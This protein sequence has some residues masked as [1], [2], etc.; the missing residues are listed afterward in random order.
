VPLLIV[1]VLLASI[2]EASHYHRDEFTQRGD[3][4]VQCSLCLHSTGSGGTP[5]LPAVLRS[6]AIVLVAHFAATPVL[7]E[8][9]GTASY[10]AR[11]PP[12][13]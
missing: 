2:A 4:H 6:A 7:V 13:V 11:G 12:S 3:T 5:H 8:S 1:A 10:D 9:I